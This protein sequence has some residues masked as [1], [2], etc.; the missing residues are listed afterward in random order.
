[1]ATR[2]PAAVVAV[3]L[4]SLTIATIVG[5]TTGRSLGKDLNDDQIVAIRSA[6]GFDVAV[7]MRGLQRMASGLALSDQ[8]VIAVEE[9]S[10]A[11]ATLEQQG[12]DNI[13]DIEQLAAAYQ[14][15]YVEPLQASGRAVNLRDIVPANSG[16][17]YIQSRY[18][19]DTGVMEDPGSLDTA[20]DGSDWTAIHEVVHPVYRDVADR[21]GLADLY[22]VDPEGNVVYS[23]N[24]RP[25]VGT[26]LDLGPFSGSALANVVDQVRTNPNGG[27]VT[28]DLAEYDPT[29]LQPVGAVAAPI[30][31]DNG[32]SGVLVLLYD[33]ERFTRL[34][35]ADQEWDDGG[36]PPTGE[37]FLV[38]ADGLTRSEP[39]SFLESPG[40][41]LA[42]TVEAGQIT[43]EEAAL[44]RASGTTLLVQRAERSTV[45]AG[46]DGR[47]SVEQRVSMTGVNTFSS[48]QSA[49][50]EGLDWFVVTE[51]ATESARGDLDEFVE[52]LVVGAAIFIIALAFLAVAWAATI[53]RP[54]RSISERLGSRGVDL[55]PVVL[56]TR[57]PIE[58]RRLAR[59]FES[60]SDALVNQ[61]EELAEAREQRL[62]LLRTMLPDA[63]AERVADE[64]VQALE[65]VPQATVCVLTVG[66]LAQLLG[67]GGGGRE[68]IEAI[69]GELDE[70]G[71]E[72]GVDRI[73][74]VGDTYFAACGHAR[75]YIDHAPRAVRFAAAAQQAIAAIGQDSGNDLYGTA[76]LHTGSVTVGV[77][78]GDR[79]LYDVWGEPTTVA[80]YLARSAE[81]RSL[82][83]SSDT[84]D[85]LPDTYTAVE[86]PGTNGADAWIITIQEAARS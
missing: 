47:T 80:H 18:S 26:S 51:V 23:V 38:G 15:T 44:I 9:M 8:A 13:D 54:V 66:G 70:L 22:L 53:V 28:G 31:G 40:E 79:L 5:V 3:A 19:V 12:D 84:Y 63:V 17:I 27:V 24:K 42:A 7:E 36:F 85:L 48:V 62:Q 61:H 75:P 83:V 2:L 43:E 76:G 39:R 78:G 4:V 34:L 20:R 69:H 81:P 46:V 35:T 16:A 71:R 64:Q 74:V 67:N 49:G 82:C 32:L 10:K 11:F 50:I 60:M 41:H 65:E 1:M 86:L 45:A 37:S 25:D 77:T 33:A 56:P 73:K 59:S 68:I 14:E 52:L 6:A 30:R 55:G 21:L 72:F 57:S 58:F 29:L